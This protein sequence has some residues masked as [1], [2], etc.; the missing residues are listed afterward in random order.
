MKDNYPEACAKKYFQINFTGDS[1]N[2]SE[3]FWIDQLD[4]KLQQAVQRQMLSDVPVGFFLSGGLDSSL[5]VAIAKKLYPDKKFPC[6]TIDTKSLEKT[7]GFTE[8]IKYAKEV[9]SFLKV[10][11]NV[12]EAELEIVKDFDKMIWHLD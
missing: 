4:E 8:D 9:A 1:S 3:K 12:L 11:L 2:K 5:I 7:E 10:D 6:F